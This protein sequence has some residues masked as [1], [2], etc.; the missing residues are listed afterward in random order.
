MHTIILQDLMALMRWQIQMLK[1]IKNAN[2]YLPGKSE[3]H[4]I[5]MAYITMKQVQSNLYHKQLSDRQ[6]AFT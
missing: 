5:S 2:V 4:Y 6:N 1:L 3:T